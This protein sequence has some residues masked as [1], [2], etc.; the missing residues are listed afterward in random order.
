MPYLPLIDGTWLDSTSA[1]QSNNSFS[2]LPPTLESACNSDSI[3]PYSFVAQKIRRHNVSKTRINPDITIIEYD[4]KCW[5]RN[6]FLIGNIQSTTNG[7]I[8]V[9]Q[10][11][12]NDKVLRVNDHSSIPLHLIITSDLRVYESEPTA[13]INLH[14]RRRYT[15]EIIKY[16]CMQTLAFNWP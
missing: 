12:E 16:H 9:Y 10:K 8:L 11:L 2:N 14:T 3:F 4:S 7:E 13:A 5:N 1:N 6:L 15:L